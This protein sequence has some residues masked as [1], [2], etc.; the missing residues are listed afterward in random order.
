MRREGEH[1]IPTLRAL[2]LP[3]LYGYIVDSQLLNLS[4]N[5]TKGYCMQNYTEI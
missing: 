4:N 1:A 5:R 2:F 3:T